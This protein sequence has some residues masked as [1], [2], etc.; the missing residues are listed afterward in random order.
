MGMILRISLFL[1]MCF[2]VGKY[3]SKYL[4][5]VR[6]YMVISSAWFLLRP[7]I[8]LH[9]FWSRYILMIGEL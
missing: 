2:E 8:L 4:D 3:I 6:C 1:K 9:D 7:S 5:S